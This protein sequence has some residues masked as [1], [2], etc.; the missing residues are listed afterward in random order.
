MIQRRYKNEKSIIFMK[1][2]GEHKHWQSKFLL[3]NKC[4]IERM[5]DWDQ[6]HLTITL[7]F[8]ERSLFHYL[9]IENKYL[10]IFTGNWSKKL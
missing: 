10:C 9:S 7:E 2:H 1:F 6:D 5:E 8:H 4:S 3:T